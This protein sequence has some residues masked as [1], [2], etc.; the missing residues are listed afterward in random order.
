MRIQRLKDKTLWIAAANGE[1][2][3]RVIISG[4]TW[5]ATYDRRRTPEEYLQMMMEKD[6]PSHPFADDVLRREE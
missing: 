4:G 2:V 5:S 6:D 1:E 3:E